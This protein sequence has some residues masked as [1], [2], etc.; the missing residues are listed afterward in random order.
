MSTR[1]PISKPLRPQGRG[2]GEVVKPPKLPT[3]IAL[4]TLLKNLNPTPEDW[5]SKKPAGAV[6]SSVIVQQATPGKTNK[7]ITA[8]ILKS[9][10][11]KV[12][13]ES[14]NERVPMPPRRPGL[15]I[16]L[17][18]PSYYEPKYFG[19][20]KLKATRGAE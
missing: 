19:P 9:D 16:N 17:P 14:R 6:L 18:P 7:T 12:Y 2:V 11:N 5:R 10:P 4:R 3:S 15:I 1:I 13:F 20:V 8:F